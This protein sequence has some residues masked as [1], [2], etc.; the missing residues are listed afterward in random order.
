MASPTQI[1]GNVSI[2]YGG[3]TRTESYGVTLEPLIYSNNFKN[4]N[5]TDNRV[6]QAADQD[7]ERGDVN[8]GFLGLV[9]L[10]NLNQYGDLQVDID[11]VSSWTSDLVLPPGAT[12]IFHPQ[13]TGSQV[14]K[15]R[16]A[17][18]QMTSIGVTSVA[19]NG[20]I[21]FDSGVA[22]PCHATIAR[23]SGG[24]SGTDVYVVKVTAA[25]TGVIY[26][27]GGNNTV[28]LNTGSVY[29][30][31]TVVTLTPF[32]DYRSIVTEG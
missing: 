5:F 28:D 14:V 25:N 24:G 26:D 8:L 6:L 20:N 27:I 22:N 13:Q 23:T 3:L 18:T 11:Y 16:C 12:N 29:T 21:V 32:V 15:C 30:S 19:T 7:L 2:N 10:K 17:L 1:T 9:L 4:F 31:S